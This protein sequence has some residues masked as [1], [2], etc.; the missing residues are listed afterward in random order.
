[1]I[2]TRGLNSNLLITRGY[3]IGSV[4]PIPSEL[5]IA[6][7]P[8]EYKLPEELLTAS[9]KVLE[10]SDGIKIVGFQK[11]KEPETFFD[12]VIKEKEIEVEEKV[13]EHL[14]KPKEIKPIE[15]KPKEEKVIESVIEEPVKP[16]EVEKI[17]VEPVKENLIVAEPLIIEEKV[18]HKNNVVSFLIGE[19]GDS[20]LFRVESYKTINEEDEELLS[21]LS[22]IL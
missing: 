10:N 2:V 19:K 14:P 21:I 12:A 4:T 3:G 18:I 11:E 22:L 17:K 6:G 15:V 1:M 5:V 16:K 20:A 7:I 13:A 8:E 9:L